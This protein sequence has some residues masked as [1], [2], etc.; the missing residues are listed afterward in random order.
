[1]LIGLIEGGEP[2]EP[3]YVFSPTHHTRVCPK[4]KDA[5]TLKKSTETQKKD[6]PADTEL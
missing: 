4:N 2:E 1:M 3:A 5:E 6:K